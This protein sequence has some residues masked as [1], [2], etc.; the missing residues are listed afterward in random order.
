MMERLGKLSSWA[1][2]LQ[3]P[4]LPDL[5][6]SSACTS[7]A[8]REANSAFPTFAEDWAVMILTLA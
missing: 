8:P 4:L 6:P 7:R 3:M 2:H 1:G 5:C